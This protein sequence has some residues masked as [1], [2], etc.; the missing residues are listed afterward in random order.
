MHALSA[1]IKIIKLVFRIFFIFGLFQLSI[2]CVNPRLK[3]TNVVIKL[4]RNPLLAFSSKKEQQPR[5]G[6][7]SSV[8][9]RSYL[10]KI[11]INVE[12]PASANPK[13]YATTIPYRL[14]P[15]TDNPIFSPISAQI[16]HKIS[17]P[18]AAMNVRLTFLD[19]SRKKDDLFQRLNLFVCADIQQQDFLIQ[20]LQFQMT[21]EH[22]SGEHLH[23]AQVKCCI[24]NI[25]IIT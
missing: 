18:K 14:K 12:N 9:L 2:K 8:F 19:I 21:L 3:L 17:I 5:I 6:F 10:P 25:R 16:I 23:S 11:V 1:V 22:A 4:K 15:K 20:F 7:I 24:L 13:V